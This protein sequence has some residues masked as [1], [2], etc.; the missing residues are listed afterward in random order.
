MTI[1]RQGSGKLLYQSINQL[2]LI[3]AQMPSGRQGR[4]QQA[5]LHMVIR[6]PPLQRCAAAAR[7]QDIARAEVAADIIAGHVRLAG[8]LLAVILIFQIVDPQL[9]IVQ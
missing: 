6:Q 7:R 1:Q 3:V 9:D 5:V 8:K 4:Q 2:L